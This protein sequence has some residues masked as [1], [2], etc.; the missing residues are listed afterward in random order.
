MSQC[1][2]C[3][4]EK[5][6]THD[7]ALIVSLSDALAARLEAAPYEDIVWARYQVNPKGFGLLPLTVYVAPKD[8]E[9]SAAFWIKEVQI[10]AGTP[11]NAAVKLVALDDASTSLQ[12]YLHESDSAFVSARTTVVRGR[13]KN[14]YFV[15][16]TSAAA[17]AT[18]RSSILGV[19]RL[20]IAA[21]HSCQWEPGKFPGVV[22]QTTLRAEGYRVPGP[23]LM[24]Y[25][26]RRQ[27]DNEAIVAVN[28][29]VAPDGRRWYHLN[30]YPVADYPEMSSMEGR[31]A[32]GGWD[33]APG[34]DEQPAW[35]FQSTTHAAHSRNQATIIVA[36]F[37][38]TA[39]Q[40]GLELDDLQA[41]V[42]E[43]EEQGDPASICNALED[44][45]LALVAH[46][47]IEA[48]EEHERQWGRYLALR[49]R[50]ERTTYA[51]EAEVAWTKAAQV[52]RRLAKNYDDDKEGNDG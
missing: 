51:N 7:D 14:G 40:A 52:L 44:L 50:A 30:L 15:L 32:I 21:L 42:A 31:L 9:L 48:D 10:S 39:V 20:D 36:V 41:K 17:P 24:I 3:K 8:A 5:C 12:L 19:W 37:L 16:S 25:D 6:S 1:P 47:Q 2:I 22:R 18:A 23:A 35:I 26:H 49:A 46:G 29:K 13:S 38:N 34:P 28:E 4:Q 11:R 27:V 45:V 33:L 43:A